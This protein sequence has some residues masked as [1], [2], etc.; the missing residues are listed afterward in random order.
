MY[1]SISLFCCRNSCW[2]HG[3]WEN[4]P[5][6]CS[7]N[8]QLQ[9]WKTPGCASP[10]ENPTVQ[11]ITNATES[12]SQPLDKHSTLIRNDSFNENKLIA[13]SAYTAIFN[14]IEKMHYTNTPYSWYIYMKYCE[15]KIFDEV[16]N[17][18]IVRLIKLNICT[19][20]ANESFCQTTPQLL[21]F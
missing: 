4:P 19:F 21:Q 17:F 11:D 5:N 16:V 7:D 13:F 1:E 15:S 6:N 12:S 3:S 10:R 18:R 9:G 2:W 20:M 14:S 8:D